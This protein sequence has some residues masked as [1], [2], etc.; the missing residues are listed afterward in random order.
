MSRL[1]FPA[2]IAASAG[3]AM[4][5]SFHPSFLLLLASAVVSA[6]R[7]EDRSTTALPNILH[8]ALPAVLGEAA[9]SASKAAAIVT[10]EILDSSLPPDS[11]ELLCNVTALAYHVDACMTPERVSNWLKI[12]KPFMRLLAKSEVPRPKNNL[13][14]G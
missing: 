13:F 3:E 9:D 12:A 7:A 6:G 8:H 11:E 5:C 2:F 14:T 10:S 1:L 4:I